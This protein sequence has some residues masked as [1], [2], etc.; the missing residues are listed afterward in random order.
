MLLYLSRLLSTRAAAQLGN[1]LIAL[2]VLAALAGTVAHEVV[3]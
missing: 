3:A 2:L 1:L